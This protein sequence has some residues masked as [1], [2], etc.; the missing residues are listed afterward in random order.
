MNLNKIAELLDE[1]ALQA[2]SVE[3]ICNTRKLTLEEAYAIQS[4]SIARRYIRGEKPVGLKM[5][6]TSKQKM[7][8]MGVHDLIWGRLTDLMHISDGGELALSK[9]IHPRAEPEIAFLI[10]GPVK[11]EVGLEN[12]KSIVSGVTTA[13]EIIDSRYKNFKFSL[14][15]VIADNCSSSAFVLGTWKSPETNIVD[16]PLSMK[17]DGEIVHE[18]NSNAILGNPWNSLVDA[19]RLALAN[20]EILDKGSIILAGAATPAT[21]VKQGQRVETVAEGFDSISLNIIA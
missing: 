18:G 3:Q 15:D 1:A 6:F 17:I 7:E 20:G 11:K 19:V 12:I 5:G 9:C 4:I 16:I 14:E 13:I 21:Y 8:Q 2:S 10:N